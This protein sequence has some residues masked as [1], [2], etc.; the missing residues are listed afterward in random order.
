MDTVF[1]D[2]TD[3]ELKDAIHDKVSLVLHYWERIADIHSVYFP[4]DSE[5]IY[6]SV[7]TITDHHIAYKTSYVFY[8]NNHELRYQSTDG[9]I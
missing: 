7:I 5:R 4:E 2:V 6:V 8:V 9:I 3:Q 1:N